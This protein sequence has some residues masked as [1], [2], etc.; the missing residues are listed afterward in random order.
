MPETASLPSRTTWHWTKPSTR[1]LRTSTEG[2]PQRGGLDRGAGALELRQ[3]DAVEIDGLA[4]DSQRAVGLNDG[5]PIEHARRGDASRITRA[6]ANAIQPRTG[7]GS[8]PV[9]TL[10][11][12]KYTGFGGDMT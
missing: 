11:R 1:S 7:S 9:S 8:C 3:I 6:N 12:Y 2:A 5:Q 10:L 4:V